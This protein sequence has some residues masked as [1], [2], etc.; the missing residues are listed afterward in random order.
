M[1]S[2]LCLKHGEK[3]LMWL[4][5]LRIA[6]IEKDTDTLDKLLDETPDL[7]GVEE[8]ESAMYLLK[9][10]ATL[11]YKLKDDTASTMKQLKKNM[12]FLESTEA[13][14]IRKFDIKS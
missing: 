4:K 10:A 3:V 14:K 2:E 13:P 1:C 6:I 12:E 11:L 7:K 5:K 8:V 9:E